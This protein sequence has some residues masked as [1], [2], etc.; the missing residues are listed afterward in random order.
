MLS[1]FCYL[2][3]K[4]RVHQKAAGMRILT[5]P[6]S[7]SHKYYLMFGLL[8]FDA[9]TPQPTARTT[10]SQVPSGIVFGTS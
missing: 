1:P 7:K 8:W 10:P 4:E 9:T 3:L 6:N 2:V 5:D